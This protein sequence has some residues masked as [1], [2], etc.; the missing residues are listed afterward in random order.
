MTSDEA[1]LE[2]KDHITKYTT[3]GEEGFDEYLETTHINIITDNMIFLYSIMDN[4]IILYYL[5]VFTKKGR[6]EATKFALE[7]F[8]EYSIRHNIPI[9]YTG[10]NNQFKNN[11]VEIEKGLY[12]FM[13]KNML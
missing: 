12:Q 7:L 3:D 5:E 9:V 13:P 2:Y 6:V 1:L 10:I 4:Y 11:S 8:D